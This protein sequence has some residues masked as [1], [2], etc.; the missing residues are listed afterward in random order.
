MP[1]GSLGWI[2]RE[3]LCSVRV[4]QWHYEPT[5]GFELLDQRRRDMLKCSCHYDCVER[6]AFRPPLVAVSDLYAHIVIAEVPQQFRGGFGKWRDNLN[7][8]NL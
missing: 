7:S 4:P 6:T 1:I 5:T 3:L 8:T 2:R